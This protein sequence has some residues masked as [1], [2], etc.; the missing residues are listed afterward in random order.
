R[1]HPRRAA[2]GARHRQ[3]RGPDR[4][5]VRRS[6]R[7]DPAARR[8]RHDRGGGGA[9]VKMT[10][11]VV[12]DEHLAVQ[13]LFDLLRRTGRVDVVGSTTDPAEAV[14]ALSAQE[15]DVLFLDIHMPEIDGFA[16]LERL[17]RAP[18]VVFTTAHDEH[19]LR[20]FQVLAIDY[21]LKPIDRAQLERAL[22][23]LER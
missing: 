12:D 21:L 13:R 10:A 3:P 11:Y 7:P 16:L 2:P 14:R 18:L 22:D 17:P 4:R 6:R 1:L 19:A 9:A 15:V 5:A 8:G 20:A 23:K